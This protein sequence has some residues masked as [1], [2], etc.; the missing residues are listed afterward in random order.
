MCLVFQFMRNFCLVNAVVVIGSCSE[1]GQL[2]AALRA[3]GYLDH[4]IALAAPGAHE[5]AS[6]LAAHLSARGARYHL[7]D[8]LVMIALLCMDSRLSRL[9]DANITLYW[10]DKASLL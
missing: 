1:P 7:A 8:L 4:N 3:P 6:M 2:A 5:R 10:H 9:Y